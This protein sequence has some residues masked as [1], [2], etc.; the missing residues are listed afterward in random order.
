M[1]WDARSS[2]LFVHIPKAGGT[3][4]EQAITM[5][6]LNISK[7][8]LKS[9]TIRQTGPHVLE[10]RIQCDGENPPH[11][12]PKQVN[13]EHV[14]DSYARA[15]LTK[16]GGYSRTFNDFV[17]SGDFTSHHFHGAPQHA[18]LSPFTRLFAFSMSKTAPVWSF[19]RKFYPNIHPAYANIINDFG[20]TKD[21]ETLIDPELRARISAI[22]KDD[23]ALFEEL[24]RGR[25]SC[26]H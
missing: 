2:L 22:Y 3:A 12:L 13:S 6:R 20:K 15:V 5:A 17:R 18:F 23:L 8:D 25:Q 16:Y 11:S 9:K 21:V 4:I 19:L 14:S 26:G 10:H 7:E 24:Q 1:M